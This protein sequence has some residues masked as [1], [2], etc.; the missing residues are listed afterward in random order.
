[1]W[2][3]GKKWWQRCISFVCVCVSVNVFVFIYIKTCLTQMFPSHL[4]LYLLFFNRYVITGLTF[5]G[6]MSTTAT[7]PKWKHWLSIK[8]KRL[9][10]T[11][12]LCLCRPLCTSEASMQSCPVESM[13]RIGA[14]HCGRL[15]LCVPD[16]E[17]AI[18]PMFL[19]SVT[20]ISENSSLCTETEIW[21]ISAVTWQLLKR[22]EQG[23]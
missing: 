14:P 12:R 11:G 20:H 21:K 7:K 16:L 2:T 15:W 5:E 13:I 22:K 9:I 17:C 23:V 1:M 4:E 19:V 8:P 10:W 6:E 3:R 18:I